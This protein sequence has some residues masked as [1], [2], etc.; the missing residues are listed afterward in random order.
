MQA[1]RKSK[2]I[3]RVQENCK[4]RN[5]DWSLLSQSEQQRQLAYAEMEL[6]RERSSR[7]H[8][9]SQDIDDTFG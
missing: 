7:R 2:V 1:I 8:A 3:L 4:R 6:L 5:Q 9:A